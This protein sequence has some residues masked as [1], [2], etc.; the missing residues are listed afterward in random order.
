MR[1]TKFWRTPQRGA[2]GNGT[3]VLT[4]SLVASGGT[5]TIE[6]HG[7]R[8]RLRPLRHATEII[9]TENIAHEPG[10]T[11]VVAFG[12]DIP[13]DDQ[14][15]PMRWALR[16]ID[17]SA[18]PGAAKPYDGFVSPHWLDAEQL[19]EIFAMIEPSTTTVRQVVEKLAGCSGAKAGRLATPFGKNRTCRTMK[20]AE[21]ADLLR[22]CQAAT[23]PI[24]PR[25]LSPLG[26]AFEAA[27]EYNKKEGEITIGRAE[28]IARLPV[29]VEAWTLVRD[30]EGTTAS[31]LKV[32]V[33]RSPIV[34]ST[35]ASRG[36]SGN[37]HGPLI[38]SIGGTHI[39]V[40]VPLG[41][42]EVVV[43]VITP[44]MP[45]ASIGKAPDINPFTELIANAVRSSFNRSR[46][47]APLTEKHPRA[48]KRALPARPP[49]LREAVLGALEQAIAHT[50]SNGAYAFS[51]R[52]L[53]YAVRPIVA[54]DVR[55]ELK[56]G[57]FADLIG[58]HENEAG[59]IVGL[60]RDPRGTFQD[61]DHVV[62]L[63]TTAVAEYA[64]PAWSFHKLLYI[65]KEDVGRVLMQAGWDR[66][67]DCAIM[68][69]K[70]YTGRAAK[71]L[72]DKI[73][74]TGEPVTIFCLHD[75]D[76]AGSMIAATLQRATRA[77]GARTVQIVDLGL[78]PWQALEM[79]LPPEPCS[80]RKP[81]P[82]SAA[83]REQGGRDW[84]VWLQK[85]RVE[86][87]ALRPEDLIEWLDREVEKHGEL[88]LVPPAAE[89]AGSLRGDVHA[90]I[91]EEE[92]RLVMERLQPL[93]DARVKRRMAVRVEAVK[94][95]KPAA[96]QRFVRT[97]LGKERQAW[98]RSVVRGT[99]VLRA[100][101]TAKADGVD[102]DGKPGSRASTP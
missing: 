10:T 1:T 95:P 55:D 82:V 68:S 50:S 42:A 31:G 18:T 14:G 61:A 67:H 26:P 71:D 99:A 60:L 49:S 46:Q 59:D 23:R 29:I 6:T 79:G 39:E 63:G 77:R 57:Y 93:I 53:Y 22:A 47:D 52:N 81:Q 41:R 56:Y 72:I 101:R 70:G 62:P 45:I 102:R 90:V 5:L 8:V 74:A 12:A 86:L 7:Q 92:R 24:K 36:W 51:L 91:E 73:A 13:D 64:R 30:R 21:T 88:K 84:P 16:A 17:A 32:F 43:H 75:A 58:D 66:R 27:S 19:A 69:S 44:H 9:S 89:L 98:W 97:K 20:L 100:T 33:N 65:E 94:L 28:P 96:L 87:N 38:L 34:S 80:Y 4:G 3:R 78:Y 85:Q 2:L 76:A 15:D 48:P 11:L 37:K 40:D 54:R 83:V 25:D 35:L